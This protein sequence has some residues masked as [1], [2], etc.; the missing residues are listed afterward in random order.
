MVRPMSKSSRKRITRTTDRP[1]RRASRSTTEAAS[2]PAAPVETT[3]EPTQAPASEVAA[4]E[5]A[6]PAL[7][8]PTYG[9]I[10]QLAFRYFAESGYL[11][12]HAFDH[13]LR[14]EVELARA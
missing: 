4:V 3:A 6:A 14:A 8:A 13:W 7:S 11:H 10:A 5:P 2:T 9:Q 12:G 1:A